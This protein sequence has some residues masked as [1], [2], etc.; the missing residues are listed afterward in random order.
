MCVWDGVTPLVKNSTPFSRPLTRPTNQ[1][2]EPLP[3]PVVLAIHGRVV[4]VVLSLALGMKRRQ[5]QINLLAIRSLIK[6]SASALVKVFRHSLG[7][8]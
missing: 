2:G 6:V 3:L 1:V 7:D 4:G 8:F 5:D